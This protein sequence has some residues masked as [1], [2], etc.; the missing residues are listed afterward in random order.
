MKEN[1]EYQVQQK[2]SAFQLEPAAEI[3]ESVDAAINKKKKRRLIVF[4]W[5][6]PLIAFLITPFF[7]MDTIELKNGGNQKQAIAVAIEYKTTPVDTSTLTNQQNNSSNS[8]TLTQQLNNKEKN[9]IISNV[10]KVHPHI[11]PIIAA[12]S[13]TKKTTINIQAKSAQSTVEPI[14]ETI[15]PEN[16]LAFA[17]KPILK[18]LDSVE[19]QE[20]ISNATANANPKQEEINMI[21]DTVATKKDSIALLAKNNATKAIDT[22]KSSSDKHKTKKKIY[23]Y[24]LIAGGAA[25]FTASTNTDGMAFATTSSPGW[26]QTGNATFNDK[27]FSAKGYY[28]SVGAGFNYALS[29]KIS[30]ITQLQYSF[31]ERTLNF[32]STKDSA[33]TFFYPSDNKTVHN[34]LHQLVL[35]QGLQL[36]DG[37]KLFQLFRP[38]I[39]YQFKTTIS[40]NWLAADYWN[41]AYINNYSTVNTVGLSIYA[42]IWFPVFKGW[43]A[44]IQYAQ[45]ITPISKY[46]QTGITGK[47]FGLT[48]KKNLSSIFNTSK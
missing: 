17:E 42:A 3:W 32:S 43:E 8:N 44:G 47:Y 46:Q 18:Q 23:P 20:V 22:T 34:Q 9:S 29:K 1:F 31:V 39:G 25:N 36:Y 12:H 21:A 48:I 10:A 14:I 28:F 45:D 4:W 37:H 41:A 16:K 27:H 26:D 30:L 40:S 11:N 5:I 35:Q 15:L 33:I 6:L 19:Q 13:I 7:L 38:E 2:A 24:I